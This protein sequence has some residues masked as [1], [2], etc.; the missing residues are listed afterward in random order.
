MRT[1]AALLVL[2]AQDA[3]PPSLVSVTAH[4]EPTKVA[5]VFSKPV[6]QAAAETAAHYSIDNGVRIESAVR[7]LDLKTVTLTTSPLTEGTPYTVRIRN[8]RDCSAP[9]L[10]VPAGT[11]KTFVFVKGLLSGSSKEESHAARMPKFAKPT[12]FNTPEADPILAGLQV[13]PKNNA[14]HEDISKRPVHPD[15]DRIV[16]TVGLDKGFRYNLDMAFVIVPPGQP[17]VDVKIASAGESDKGPYPVPENAPIEGW[18]MD[19]KTL[20]AAQRA[21]GSDRHMIVVDAANGMLYEFYQAFRRPTGWEAASE[22]TFDLK[23]NKLRPRGWTSSDAAGLPLFASLPRFEECERGVVDHAL[24]VTVS[25]TRRAFIYPATH[26]AGSA[27]SPAV[28]AMGQRFRLKA[29]VDISGFPRHAQAIA[30]ALKKHGMLVADNGGDWEIS[31]PPDSRF[32]GLEALRKLRGG[33]FEVVVTTGENE[34]GR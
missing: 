18:P 28:P 9:P 1:L 27:D 15:S 29:A 25:K 31:I 16:A 24:R 7:G 30:A 14:W 2:L 3:S 33:D 17:R 23:T 34:L 13:F 4:G 21:G 10:E 6:D 8:V 5:I 22:A 32:R 26:Q 19:G 20:E 12:L 11:L